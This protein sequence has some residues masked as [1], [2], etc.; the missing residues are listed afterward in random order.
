MD[1]KQPVGRSPVKRNSKGKRVDSGKRQ[2]I[3]NAYKS[4]LESDSTKSLRTI[5]QELSKELGIGATTISTTITE[6][7]N[8]K[9]VISPSKTRIKTSFRDTY[10]EEFERNVVRRHVHSFWF[11]REIPTVDKIHKAVSDDDSLPNISRTNLFRLLKDMEFRYSKRSRNSALTEKTEIVLWRRR[12]LEQLRKYRDEGR[13]LYYLDE[14]WVNAGECTSKTWIDTTIKSPRDAFLQGLT[15]GAVNP[16]GKGKR[17]IVLHIGSEDGFVPGALLCFESKKNTRDYHDEMNGETFYEWMEGVLPRLKENSVII[18][19]NASYHSVKIDKAPT[20]QNKKDDIIKWLVDKGEI[21]DRHMVIQQ[22]L[23]IVKRIKPQHQKYAVDELAKKHNR[24][25][26]RLPPY[27]CE[28]NPIELAWSSVKN[29]VKMNNK[30]YKLPDVKKLLIEGVERVNADMWKNFISHTKKEEDKFWEIDF[31][32]DDVLSAEVEP[33]VM[34]IG[35][36]TSDE[37]SEI[38]SD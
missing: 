31:I 37:S 23:E 20:S 9:T 4:K 3:I 8:S 11:K 6:Y 25:I 36:T 38:E 32:V 21:I 14:T 29:Y 26:L 13:H 22:L 10:Y 28:L 30:T 15:T 12:Y 16:T 1:Q 33:V 35:D 19:D 18:M 34:T 7:N 2:M 24:V 27:H 5:R 17:L